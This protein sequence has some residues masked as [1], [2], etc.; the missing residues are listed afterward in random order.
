MKILES[1]RLIENM[2]PMINFFYQI[3]QVFS[4]FFA[5]LIF[6]IFVLSWL[7]IS[8]FFSFF[9]SPLCQQ[10]SYSNDVVITRREKEKNECNKMKADNSSSYSSPSLLNIMIPQFQQLLPLEAPLS[11]TISL[12]KKTTIINY[13][14]FLFIFFRWQFFSCSLPVLFV[15]VGSWLNTNYSSELLSKT[16]HKLPSP[17]ISITP[18]SICTG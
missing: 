6:V 1:S 14:S 11:G 9:S 5:L 4:S 12:G 3:A 18:S 8:L 15:Y 13:T 16:T 10:F 7:D 2:W 17:P